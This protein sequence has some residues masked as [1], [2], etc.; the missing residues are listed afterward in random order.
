VL[1]IGGRAVRTLVTDRDCAA[2]ATALGFNG[3]NDGGAPLP[4]GRYLV[5]IVA[6]ADDG[7]QVSRCLPVALGP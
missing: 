4:S 6:R 5:E 1:N 2:G 3:R 7:Q